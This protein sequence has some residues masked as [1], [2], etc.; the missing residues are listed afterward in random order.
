MQYLAVISNSQNAWGGFIVD[1]GVTVV[2]K[3]H[4]QVKTRLEEG[5]ALHLDTL[6]DL[7]LNIQPTKTRTLQ[8]IPQ[9]DLE[10]LENLQV[11]WIS[12]ATMNPV[13]K[14][15]RKALERSG[16]SDSEVARRMGTSPAAIARMKDDF[17]FGH[18]L[19]TIN[20]LA[21]VLDSKWEHHLVQ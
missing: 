19:Q 1:L 3:S 16:L 9:E 2:G 18:S 6:Q 7:G 20:R 8:D 5:L 13:S 12:P 4:E 10:D 21:A 14:E 17:Y 11:V 15:I